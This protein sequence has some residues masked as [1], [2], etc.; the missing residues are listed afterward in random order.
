[1]KKTLIILGLVGILALGSAF[2]YADSL[3]DNG[4]NNI[5]KD[6]PNYYENMENWHKERMEGRKEELKNAVEDGRIA[7]EV[8]EKWEAHFDYMEN[9]H[10]ENGFLGNGWCHGRMGKG[11]GMMGRHMIGY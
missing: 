5:A 7:P 2:V 9:F 3:S 8:S 6:N 10:K 1:M 11:K 4:L